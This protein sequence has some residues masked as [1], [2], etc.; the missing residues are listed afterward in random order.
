LFGDREAEARNEL[1][2]SVPATL[3]GVLAMLTYVEDVSKGKYSSSGRPDNAFDRDDL[4]NVIISAQD[5]LREVPW[6]A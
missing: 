4:L 5:C 6:P 3:A 2:S 1:A